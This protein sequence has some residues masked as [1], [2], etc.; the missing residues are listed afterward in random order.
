MNG[1]QLWYEP[2]PVVVCNNI[3]VKCVIVGI[4]AYLCPIIY[5]TSR[6]GSTLLLDDI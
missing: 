3:S 5:L 6:D 1:I 2:A 4:F